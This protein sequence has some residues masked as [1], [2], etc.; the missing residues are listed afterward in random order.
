VK[1]VYVLS[2][3]I[4]IVLYVYVC[5]TFREVET[6]KAWFVTWKARNEINGVYSIHLQLIC[7]K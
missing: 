1:Q 7:A 6:K 2:K 5:S 4:Q 3:K